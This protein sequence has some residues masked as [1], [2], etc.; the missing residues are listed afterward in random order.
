MADKVTTSKTLKL[1]AKFEDNDTRTLDLDNPKD[2]LTAA[3]IKAFETVAKTTQA[4]I[5]DK[6]GANFY[7]FTDAKTIEKET[8]VL[9][10]R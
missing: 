9:D 3:Q 8:T 5:G 4:I 10:L 6:G 1:V 7:K 2:N